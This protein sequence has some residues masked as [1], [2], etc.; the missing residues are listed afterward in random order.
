MSSL[1]FDPQDPPEEPPQQVRQP[2]MWRLAVRLYRD[3]AL[4]AAPVGAPPRCQVCRQPWPCPPRR[5][6]ERG[7]V[8]AFAEPPHRR[9]TR[10]FGPPGGPGP[11]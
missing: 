1:P 6:A 7:L 2:M 9:N 3:H 5:T 11:R 10:W 8:A 4:A